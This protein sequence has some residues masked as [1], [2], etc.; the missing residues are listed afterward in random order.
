MEELLQKSKKKGGRN[1]L[2]V[3]LGIKTFKSNMA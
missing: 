1:G 3:F 2:K